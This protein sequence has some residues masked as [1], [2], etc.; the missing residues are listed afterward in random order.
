MN[1]PSMKARKLL[2]LLQRAPL[3]YSIDEKKAGS[4]VWLVSPKFPRLRWGFHMNRD[5]PGGLVR[6]ILMKQVG[7]SEEDAL[8]LIG[9]KKS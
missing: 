9:G 3:S 5:L 4:H 7:L 1:F 6:E 2:Q 8:Q